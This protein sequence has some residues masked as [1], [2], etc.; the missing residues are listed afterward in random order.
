MTSYSGASAAVQASCKLSHICQNVGE[1]WDQLFLPVPIPGAGA[2]FWV[3]SRRE[4]QQKL[5]FGVFF[6]SHFSVLSSKLRLQLRGGQ[7]RINGEN[8]TNNI[9]PCT[10]SIWQRMA[11]RW[12]EKTAKAGKITACPP[13][14][15]SLAAHPSWVHLL[16]W[17]CCQLDNR[18]LQPPETNDAAEEGQQLQ[19]AV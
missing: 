12:R 18:D 9:S 4:R 2:I 16:I 17:S 7:D 6:S 14:F 19:P 1:D 5:K 11:K 13:I 15:H 8:R 10:S 3:N